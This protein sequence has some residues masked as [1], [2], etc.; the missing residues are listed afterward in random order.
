MILFKRRVTPHSHFLFPSTNTIPSHILRT[1]SHHNSMAT[2]FEI[3]PSMVVGAVYP[4]LE[5]YAKRESTSSYVL[6]MIEFELG[7]V[8]AAFDEDRWLDILDYIDTRQNGWEEVKAEWQRIRSGMYI[9]L[10]QSIDV[11]TPSVSTIARR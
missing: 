4:W 7:A 10:P 2:S 5:S 3:S 9:G 8:G 6:Q 1:I 11:F